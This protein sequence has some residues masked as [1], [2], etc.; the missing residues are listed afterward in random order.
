MSLIVSENFRALF[1]AP[2]YLAHATGAY[3]IQGVS[4]SL[5]A[6]PSPAES[7]RMLQE[8]SVDVM[9]GGPLRVLMERDTDPSCTMKCFQAVVSRDPFF[10][11]GRTPAPDFELPSL[12]SIRLATVAEVPTPWLCLQDDLRR[13]GIDPASLDRRSDLP[14]ADSAAALRRGEIDAVQVFQPH[15]EDLLRDGAAHLWYAAATRG[16]TSYTNFVALERTLQARRPELLAMTRAMR[17]TL[18][19][20]ATTPGTEIATVLAPYFPDLPT[21]LIA[22]CVDRY[23]AL[24]LWND[25]AALLREGFARL[26]NAML[27]GGAI[28][29]GASFEECVDVGLI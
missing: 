12:A 25:D 29:R 8:G 2:F 18:Q 21:D 27:S 3:D 7:A 4:V 13:A 14:M 24:Q 16:P 17:A 26:R 23:R 28:T 22:A 9:W 1:Y 20:M 11:L 10:I 19:W 15:A 6:S 5:Q